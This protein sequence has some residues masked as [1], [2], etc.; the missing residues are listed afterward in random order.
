MG[1][2]TRCKYTHSNLTGHETHNTRKGHAG[3]L[4]QAYSNHIKKS[5]PLPTE[6]LWKTRFRARLEAQWL[7]KAM[8]TR[9]GSPH[10]PGGLHDCK[11]AASNVPAAS[12]ENGA[13]RTGSFKPGWHT[14]PAIRPVMVAA[15]KRYNMHALPDYCNRISLT[16]L[17]VLALV[18]RA[19]GVNVFPSQS[20]NHTLLM[21]SDQYRAVFAQWL[22][23]TRICTIISRLV[24]YLD[25]A[26]S[27][28][29]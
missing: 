17:P 21:C 23:N 11:Q 3:F 1:D 28:E 12:C 22:F 8:S 10:M 7:I 20:F 16:L 2:L 24:H 19:R 29:P 4:L 18:L 15:I 26:I 6:S 5:K 9:R 13:Q 25:W 27:K 14:L